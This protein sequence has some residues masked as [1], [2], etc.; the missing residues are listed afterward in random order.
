MNKG[1]INDQ[2]DNIVSS[3]EEIELPRVPGKWL[4]RLVKAVEEGRPGRRISRK[5]E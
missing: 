5:E 4:N 3:V 1:E 2:F